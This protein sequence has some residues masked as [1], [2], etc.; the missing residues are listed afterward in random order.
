MMRTGVMVVTGVYI[1]MA[2]LGYVVAGWPAVG[3]LVGGS[4]VGLFILDMMAT[5]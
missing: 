5:G 3:A 2:V 4:L 1:G